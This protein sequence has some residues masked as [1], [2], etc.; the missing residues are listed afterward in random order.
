MT[1]LGAFFAFLIGLLLGL[2]GGGG[3]VLTVPVF[4]YL[5]DIDPKPAIAMSMPVVGTASLVGAVGHWRAGNVDVRSALLFGLVAMAGAFG[6][7]RLAVFVSGAVQLALLG[8]V[9]L[10]VAT[11]M[12]RPASV[13]ESLPARDASTW[14]LLAGTA[15]G[16]GLLTGLVGIGGGFLIVPALVL[17]VGVPMKRA[18]GTSLL[19]IAMNSLSGFLGYQGQVAVSWPFIA[20]FTSVAVVG[21]VV[22]TRLVQRVGATA[23]R[24][25]FALFLL[26]M[27]AFVLWRNRTVFRVGESRLTRGE[28]AIYSSIVE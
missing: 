3:S 10:A 22:G 25:G 28:P 17:L 20:A 19:V 18:V 21:I 27:A 23:L 14:A 24:R 9:M 13:R 15:L 2:L 5:L 4:V 8:V 26:A 7:A 11:S 6:G 12:L 1:P 16:V